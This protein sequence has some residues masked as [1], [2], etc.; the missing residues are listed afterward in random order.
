MKK[1]KLIEKILRRIKQTMKNRHP[2]DEK[3]R[4]SDQNAILVLTTAWSRL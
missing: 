4:R 1:K 3:G 2:V